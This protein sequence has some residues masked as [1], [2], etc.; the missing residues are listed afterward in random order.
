VTVQLTIGTASRDEVADLR[1]WMTGTGANVQTTSRVAAPNA[2]GS[3]WDLLTVACEAGGPVVGAVRALQ[4]W[5]ESRVTSVEIVVGDRRFT[6]T[7]QDAATVLPEVTKA[8]LALES[9]QQSDAS[10]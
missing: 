5:I 4:L 8:V 7:T 1:E 2:Q 6:V 10:A 9:G 3:V